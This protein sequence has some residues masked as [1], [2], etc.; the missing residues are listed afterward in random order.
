MWSRILLIDY[1]FQTS[2]L[3]AQHLEVWFD[4]MND[5]LQ[6]DKAASSTDFSWSQQGR[7]DTVL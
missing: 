3:V 4:H 6:V 7:V 5:R 1:L 2:M